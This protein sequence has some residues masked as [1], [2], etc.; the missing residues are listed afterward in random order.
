MDTQLMN[1]G[2]NMFKWQE[3]SMGG[4]APKWVHEPSV[5]AIKSIARR[6]FDISIAGTRS[7]SDLET[8][9]TLSSSGS[10]KK[11]YKDEVSAS[12][13]DLPT[14]LLLND[15]GQFRSQNDISDVKVTF[16]AN[17]SFNKLYQV[18]IPDS[19][20]AFLMRIP[21]PIDPWFK[22]RSE[23][24]TIETVR[25]LTSLSLPSILSYCA[26]TRNDLHL[27]WFLMDM[28]PGQTLWSLW[29]SL[30][31]KQKEDVVKNIAQLHVD[32]FNARWSSIGS[33]G[34]SD[35]N[36]SNDGITETTGINSSNKTAGNQIHKSIHASNL[37]DQDIEEIN[38]KKPTQCDSIFPLG[39]VVQQAFSLASR[40][41][42]K[43]QRG[44]FL[45]DHDWIHAL[46]MVSIQTHEQD[47]E[48]SDD[49]GTREDAE[50]YAEVAKKL[51]DIL[52]MVFP[53]TE[54]TT[55]CLV[56]HDLSFNNIMIDKTGR[57]TGIIDWEC[58]ST[59]PLWR[60]CQLPKL[61][62]G[63]ARDEMPNPMIYGDTD[64]EDSKS[65]RNFC[66]P[67]SDNLGKN[68]LYW[69]HLLDWEKTKMTETF[70][71]EMDRL[72]P[73]W[74]QIQE[75][76]QMKME[77]IELVEDVAACAYAEDIL[78]WIQDFNDAFTR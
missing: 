12:E 22:T 28:L 58:V 56:H 72:A 46:L 35:A 42:A 10:F 24:F 31:M 4:W 15:S 65:L 26:D 68:S 30:S 33:L 39:P 36:L 5:A 52:P 57:I 74:R 34:T 23:V 37:S 51:L 27:E 49:E 64:E 63:G 44:P 20:K 6:E 16:F 1:A 14:R 50:I 29:R 73:E 3:R 54:P 55:T 53:P 48:S 38:S 8:R 13:R 61:L 71:I 77:F 66:M 2:A 67:V 59:L 60:A 7:N 45:S 47:L 21:L 41:Q 18:E 62:T 76:S 43:T 19:P 17:G 70:M 9:P 25:R 32:L 69:R 40:I 11:L 75:T 78:E